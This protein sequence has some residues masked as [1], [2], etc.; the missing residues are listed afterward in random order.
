MDHTLGVV[1]DELLLESAYP[2]RTGD[3]R[4]SLALAIKVMKAL[5]HKNC[6]QAVYLTAGHAAGAWET[7]SVAAI[8]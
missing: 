8:V 4:N 5:L 7:V 3:R 6:V 1:K 2:L